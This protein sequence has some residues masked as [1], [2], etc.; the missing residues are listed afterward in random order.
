MKM[1]KADKRT[2]A[3]FRSL[4]PAKADIVVKPMFG[5][6]AAFVNGNLFAGTFGTQVF[7]RLSEQD[8]VIL[9]KA[10]GASGFSPM[11]GRPMRGYIVMPSSWAK[12]PGKA[13]SW[14]AKSLEWTS[15]IPPK[16]KKA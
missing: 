1:P 3:F 11:E 9:M 5:H 16:P 15:K 14:V 8:G 13:R 4:L 12:E 2:E 6:A 10:K 7:V